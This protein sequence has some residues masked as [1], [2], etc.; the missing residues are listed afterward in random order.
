MAKIFN[1]ARL[2]LFFILL[3]DGG[4]N[5]TNDRDF[6]GVWIPKDI[7]L[8]RDLTPTEKFLLVEIDSLSKNGECFASNEHFAQFLG[9]STRQV[10]YALK[11]LKDKGLISTFLIY[12]EGTKEVEKRIITPHEVYF[13]TPSRNAVR[14]PHETGFATPHEI[15]FVDNN[16]I[17]NNTVNNTSNIKKI[18]KKNSSSAEVDSEFELLWAKYPRKIGKAKAL[19]SYIK[20]RK[21][22][23]YTYEQIENGLNKYIEYIETQG[24]DEQFIQHGSTWFNQE[25]WLDD[26]I[27]TATKKKPNN[28]FDFMRNEYGGGTF[29][30]TRDG[31]IIDYDTTDIPKFF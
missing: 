25:K 16:T 9:I 8:N 6:K 7:Y 22:K 24:T 20:A 19:Q 15:D 18:N 30:R 31:N 5:M 3:K 2:A 12:R 11:K 28:V 10:Q 23:K 26:Y 14:D 27:C 17:I 29:E 1:K 21:V 4:F 13:T